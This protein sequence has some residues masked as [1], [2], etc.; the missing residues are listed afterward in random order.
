MSIKFPAPTL[1]V[2]SPE[3]PPPVKPE[4]AT[5]EVMSPVVGVWK[6]TAPDRDW[7]T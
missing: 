3:D 7:E 6:V 1:S 4:P 5:T 2:T